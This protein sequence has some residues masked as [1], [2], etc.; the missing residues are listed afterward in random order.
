MNGFVVVSVR[1]SVC[2]GRSGATA[3]GAVTDDVPMYVALDHLE[4]VRGGLKGSN[5]NSCGA[6][7]ELVVVA[8][9]GPS[10]DSELEFDESAWDPVFEQD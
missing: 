9:D 2:W 5:C 10:A 6:D 4:W 8:E 7:M 3:E 1:C